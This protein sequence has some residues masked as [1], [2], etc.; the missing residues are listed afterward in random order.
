MT[1]QQMTINDAIA[2]HEKEINR[3]VGNAKRKKTRSQADKVIEYLNRY[4]SMTQR[5]ANA[6]GVY[7]LP[8][9]VYDINNSTDP[10]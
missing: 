8:A 7:R 3:I 4:G 1:M 2:E 9:R 6:I 5:D 10:K